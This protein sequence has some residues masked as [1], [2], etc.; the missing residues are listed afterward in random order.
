[1][2][3]KPKI[4]LDRLRARL[5][6]TAAEAEARAA[7]R[8]QEDEAQE[9]ER[10]TR[11]LDMLRRLQARIDSYPRSEPEGVPDWVDRHP[12]MRIV[13]ELQRVWR[14]H[15]ATRRSKAS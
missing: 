1:M 11:G 4:T 14:E 5:A 6:E 9:G 10:E 2:N 13:R 12:E 3:E 7:R 8:R 15:A